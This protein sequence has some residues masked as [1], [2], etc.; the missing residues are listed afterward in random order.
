MY[1]PP[2]LVVLV[3][4]IPAMGCPEKP[5]QAPPASSPGIAGT[6]SGVTASP[7]PDELDAARKKADAAAE[8][9]VGEL[10][11][12]LTEAVA[13]RGAEGAIDFCN[14]VAQELTAKLGER[15]GV[16]IRRTA[17]RLRN[18]VN[19][20]DPFE[21]AFLERAAAKLAAGGSVSPEA[22]VQPATGGGRELRLLRPIVYRGGICEQCHGSLE[23]ISPGV[24]ARLAE[25]YPEDQATG[26]KSGEL[27]GAV[28][29]RVPL[30]RP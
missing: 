4:L 8:A 26:F 29:V 21:R 23:G 6:W 1:R 5:A 11:A 19:A 7:V 24:R 3:L 30:G 17:L 28:S 2:A 15:E 13:A 14:K 27:R 20:P 9:L 18:K 12:K 10:S 16:A 25:R 22:E